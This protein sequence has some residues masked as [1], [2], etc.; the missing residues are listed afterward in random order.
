MCLEKRQEDR[1][2]DA[3]ALLLAL[4]RCRDAGGWSD[5]DAEIWWRTSGPRSRAAQDATGRIPDGAAAPFHSA[6][7]ADV[8]RSGQPI[9]GS[10][11]ADA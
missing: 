7:T 2:K 3:R 6:P 1:P 10:L 9:V 5:E 4:E 11:R 8:S